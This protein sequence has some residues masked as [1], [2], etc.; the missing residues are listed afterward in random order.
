[1][2]S[3]RELD[4]TSSIRSCVG[5]G[6]LPPAHDRPHPDCDSNA[7]FPPESLSDYFRT[8]IVLQLLLVG[9]LYETNMYQPKILVGKNVARTFYRTVPRKQP[10]DTAAADYDDSQWEE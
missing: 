9:F 7:I 4:E 1:M 5:T 3:G 6:M 2:Y 10:G 8:N